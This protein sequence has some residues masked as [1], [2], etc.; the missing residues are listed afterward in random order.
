MFIM[1]APNSTP[2]VKSCTGWKR[3]SVN[4][5][6]KQDFPTPA[7]ARAGEHQRGPK[8]HLAALDSWLV[9]AK[10]L[11]TRVPDDNVLEQV[12]VS[13]LALQTCLLKTTCWR[14]QKGAARADLRVGHLPVRST[15][16]PRLLCQ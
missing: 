6:N 15:S 11:L 16:G 3:L 9:A 5:S 8:A 1:R 13:K 4:C 10:V 7:Q 12:P 2:I 14:A